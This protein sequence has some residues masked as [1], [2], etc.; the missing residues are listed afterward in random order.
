[1]KKITALMVLI[2]SMNVF[3]LTLDD[4][5]QSC[6]I[7]GEYVLRIENNL[8]WDVFTT[9]GRSLKRGDSVEQAS[10]LLNFFSQGV[11]SLQLETDEN[12]IAD[13]ERV[14]P[15]NCNM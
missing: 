6:W 2:L 11:L 7:R 3:A 15:S 14:N 5:R 8:R 12:G 10:N 1:M 4:I 13:F 9:E